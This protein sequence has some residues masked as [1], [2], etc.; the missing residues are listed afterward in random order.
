[1]EIFTKVHKDQAKMNAAATLI[2]EKICNRLKR[3]KEGRELR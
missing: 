1:M 2:Q 3:Q